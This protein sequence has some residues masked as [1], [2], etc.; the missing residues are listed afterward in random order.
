MAQAAKLVRIS[1]SSQEAL[2]QLA[3]S[4]H[5]SM[6]AVLDKA[7]EEYRRAQMF[8]EA[9]SAFASLKN[10]PAAWAEERRER[11]LWDHALQDG[12]EQGEVWPAE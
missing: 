9:D 4:Q 6:Q 11:E 12:L 7:I 10:D 3:R 8:A 1:Q 2:R 5:A